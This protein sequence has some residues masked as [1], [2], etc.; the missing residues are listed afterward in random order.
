MK[1]A[2]KDLQ[3]RL[4][5]CNQ[6]LIVHLGFFAHNLMRV[7]CRDDGAALLNTCRHVQA[8]SAR[9]LEAQR[10]YL[11]TGQMLVL[12]HGFDDLTKQ[13]QHSLQSA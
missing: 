2:V 5:V 9:V 7:V 4:D 6:R 8:S 1:L 12:M 13:I 3:R 11:L 10:A